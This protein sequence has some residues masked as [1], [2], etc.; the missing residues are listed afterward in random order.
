MFGQE[1]LFTALQKERGEE[2]LNLKLRHLH[3]RSQGKPGFGFVP[4]GREQCQ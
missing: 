1:C 3:S 2:M 4:E